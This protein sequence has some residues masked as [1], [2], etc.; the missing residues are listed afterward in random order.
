MLK[1]KKCE[2]RWVDME[3]HDEHLISQPQ[4]VIGC[5]ALAEKKIVA[6]AKEAL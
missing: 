3:G 2:V 1:E 6:I 4:V 5:A